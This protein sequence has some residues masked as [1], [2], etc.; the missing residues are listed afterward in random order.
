MLIGERQKIPKE[1]TSNRKI[2]T[3]TRK[4]CGLFCYPK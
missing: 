3:T 1:E 2:Y 4:I